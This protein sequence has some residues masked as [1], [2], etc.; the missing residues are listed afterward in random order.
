MCPRWVCCW[1]ACVPDVI[2]VLWEVPDKERFRSA[3]S[4]QQV[5]LPG[6]ELQS[7]SWASAYGAWQSLQPVVGISWLAA[8]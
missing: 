3:R 8:G 1:G 5:S 4:K 2:S 6:T 7:G